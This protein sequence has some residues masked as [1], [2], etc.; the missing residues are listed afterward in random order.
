MFFRTSITAALLCL[1]SLAQGS[2]DVTLLSQVKTGSRYSGCWGYIAPDGREFAIVGENSATLIYETSDP[3]NP[4]QVGRFSA[5]PSKWREI[6]SYGPYVYSVSE[7]HSGIRVIDMTTPGT[8]VDRG[9][10]H[11]ADWRSTHSISVDPDA[12]HIYVNGCGSPMSGMHI[13][14]AKNSP[15]TLPILASFTLD[16]VHDCHVRR[17][18]AY[19][20]HINRGTQRILDVTNLAAINTPAA[21][22]ALFKTPGNF[23]HSSWVSADDQV[24]ITTDENRWGR[25]KAW[26]ISNPSTPVGHG[27]YGT[28]GHIVHNIFML[29]RTAY[30]AH[31]SEGFHMVDLADLN[32]ITMVARYDTS[33]AG[34]NSGY[35]GDWGLYPFQD[36]GVV[37][38]T[39]RVEGLHIFQVD[40]GHLNRY[41]KG[42]AN[43]QGQTPHAVQDGATPR[44]GASGYK[45]QVSGLQPAAHFATL[46][47]TQ[48]GS[49]QLF[50]V[51]IL[52]DTSFMLT[53]DGTA[54]ASGSATVP[55]AIPQLPSLA[56]Q[57]IY[58][59]IVAIDASAPA[60]LT[61]SRGIWFGIAP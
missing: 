52:I 19:L 17:G 34:A 6:T 15:L 35:A 57:R 55:L 44:V 61:A 36:S 43:A 25:L 11:Q 48:P 30:I 16:Y 33:T 41:G 9:Y 37:Y 14:D 4:V 21:T 1:P 60:G 56:H 38:A 3:R 47:S 7:G 27:D 18:K 23:T 24:L 50:G 45:F 5:N 51:D 13:L 22:I 54:D 40:V 46:I 59:Q 32:Q 28:N 39:D 20:S 58:A 42:S 29:G 31:N 8:P 53:L 12:G 2:Q 49:Q 26:D 10:I